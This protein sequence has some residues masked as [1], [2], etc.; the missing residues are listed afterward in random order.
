M[1]NLLKETTDRLTQHGKTWKDVRW[2]G[3]D[4]FTMSVDNFIE[5]ARRTDYDAGFG[6]P[7]VATDLKIVGDDWFLMRYDYDGAE[8][9]AYVEV[10]VKPA[11]ECTVNKLAK[12]SGCCTL[13]ECNAE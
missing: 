11:L 13:S 9:L 4:D 6:S 10:P 3:G 2:I 12:A 8:G 1:N 7:L 5:V